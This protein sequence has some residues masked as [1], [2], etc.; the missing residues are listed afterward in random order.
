MSFEDGI[1]VN[2]DDTYK[3]SK[4]VLNR[5]DAISADKIDVF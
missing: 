1:S 4:I 2:E 3:T 5:V